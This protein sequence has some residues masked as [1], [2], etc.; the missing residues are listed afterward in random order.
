MTATVLWK[1]A[2]GG[3]CL[4]ADCS[5][6]FFGR[7]AEAF[8]GNPIKLE[9]EPDCEKLRAMASASESYGDAFNELAD[10]VADHGA[11]DVWA[12]Y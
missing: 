9:S 5:S 11:I 3:R 12:E 10:L 8:G 2:G 4:K 7:L 1:I 6:T